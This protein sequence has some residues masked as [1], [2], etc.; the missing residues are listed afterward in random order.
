[1]ARPSLGLPK[2]TAKRAAGAKST[3]KAGRTPAAAASQA[4]VENEDQIDIYVECDGGM[5][6]VLL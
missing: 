2:R 5:A 3:L 1:M 6:G 4:N